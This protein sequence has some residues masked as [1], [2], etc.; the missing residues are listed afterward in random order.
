MVKINTHKLLELYPEIKEITE[1]GEIRQTIIQSVNRITGAK[2]QEVSKSK[3]RRI[4]K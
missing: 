2:L 3:E 4:M 1:G